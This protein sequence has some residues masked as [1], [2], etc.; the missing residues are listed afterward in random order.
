ML[1]G[2]VCVEGA[3]LPFPESHSQFF[4][5]NA[6][7]SFSLSAK[8]LKPVYL[9]SLYMEWSYKKTERI[10]RKNLMYRYHYQI[11]QFKTG[12]SKQSH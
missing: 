8:W 7:I 3:S 10:G 5:L 6:C 2:N 12:V 4:V 9:P 1:V 11:L